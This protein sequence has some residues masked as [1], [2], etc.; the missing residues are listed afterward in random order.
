MEG[1]RVARDRSTPEIGGPLMSTH[2][3]AC[4]K[5][6]TAAQQ[7]SV[8]CQLPN[9][10]T[11]CLHGISSTRAEKKEL[12]HGLPLVFCII[13]A[14]TTIVSTTTACKF[15]LNS[16]ILGFFFF[17]LLLFLSLCFFPLLEMICLGG[18]LFFSLF[19]ILIKYI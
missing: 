12:A 7:A 16:F 9:G 15:L 3:Q 8:G 1:R 4:P 19:L 17:F 5:A 14:I 13:P 6:F 11:A 10:T 18:S 2:I